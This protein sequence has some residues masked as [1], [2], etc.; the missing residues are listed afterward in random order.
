MVLV[1]RNTSIF[2]Y[3]ILCTKN[4]CFLEDFFLQIIWQIKNTFLGANVL[5][6]VGKGDWIWKV[7]IAHLLC[8]DIDRISRT[9][10]WRDPTARHID[11]LPGDKEEQEDKRNCKSSWFVFPLEEKDM[12]SPASSDS[13]EAGPW[14]S[15]KTFISS[16]IQYYSA[17]SKFSLFLSLGVLFI[18]IQF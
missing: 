7:C 12:L 17:S 10:I 1:K 18:T 3:V 8:S 6:S 2:I 16:W 9:Q 4:N 13:E 5:F 11:A 15:S 14:P